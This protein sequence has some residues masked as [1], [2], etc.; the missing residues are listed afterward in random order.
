MKKMFGIIAILLFVYILIQFIF[1]LII[2]THIVEYKLEENKELYNIKEVFTARYQTLYLNKR[3]TNSYYYEISDQ[4][5]NILSSFKITGKYKGFKKYLKRIKVYKDDNLFCIYPILKDNDVLLDVICKK[6]DEQVLYANLKGTNNNL[7]LFVESLKKLGYSHY[8]WEKE[9]LKTTELENVKIYK[10]NLLDD[11]YIALW[12]YKGIYNINKEK[13]IKLTLLL[14][15]QYDNNLSFIL[16]NYYIIPN[17]N[18]KNSFDTLIKVNLKTSVVNNFKLDLNIAY[19][20]FIQGRVDDDI[21]IVDKANNNQYKINILKE[22]ISLFGYIDRASIYYNGKWQSKTIYDIVDNNLTFGFDEKI[23]ESLNNNQYLSID[24]VLGDTD[25]YYYMYT[26]SDN[27]VKAYRIDKQNTSIKTLLFKVPNISNIKY[28]NK[29]I[30]FIS[31]DIL[32]MY[33]DET[34]LRPLLKY[35]E[36]IFNK[37]NMYEIYIDD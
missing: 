13:P 24:S 2:G 33:S 21:Y 34:G 29:S 1:G 25:G 22:K 8:S 18:K 28:I 9:D 30:Y 6:N 31:E 16:N 7:D 10:N 14:N 27:L 37:S 11:Q 15:D 3:D 4:K 20:S 19:N 17:Y 12:N 32:Y 5:N 23:P 36:L 35:H 26:S